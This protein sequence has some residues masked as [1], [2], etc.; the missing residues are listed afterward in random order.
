MISVPQSLINNYNSLNAAGKHEAEKRIQ[1]LTEIPRYKK[2]NHDIAEVLEL[3]QF[4]CPVS[5]GEGIYISDDYSD[6]IT[7][8]SNETT[9]KADFCVTVSGDSMQPKY[10]S[11]DILLVRS[12]SSVAVGDI[13]IFAVNGDYF[14]KQQGTDE[15]ISLNPA[16]S[17]IKPSETDSVYCKGKV[18]G[19]LNADW[20]AK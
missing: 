19:I 18:I 1:E 6:N 16:R 9:R 5:A 12:Q 2:Y 20:I 14:V 7:V 3:P 15:L 17:N 8:I 13:G 10:N 4:F 11:G